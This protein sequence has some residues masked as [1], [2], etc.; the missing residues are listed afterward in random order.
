M[1]KLLCL[2]AVV[3]I[4]ALAGN[5]WTE[6]W[7]V[8]PDGSNA[9][10]GQAWDDAFQTIQ[11]AI[12]SAKNADEIWVAA[13]R[14]L[15]ENTPSPKDYI[16]VQK[17][18]GIYGGF[19]GTEMQRQERD[20]VKN[21]T[22]VDGGNQVLCFYVKADATID[23]FTIT[24]GYDEDTGYAGGIRNDKCSPTI[25]NC[26]FRENNGKYNGGGIYNYQESSPTIYNCVFIGNT[27][28]NFGG[29]IYNYFKSSPRIINCTFH[30]NSAK[31]TGGAIYNYNDSSPTITNC[32]FSENKAKSGGGIYN[33][34]SSPII[35]N[36]VLWGDTAQEG[37]EI[38]G[39]GGSYCD[40]AYS[41]IQGG[42]PGSENIDQHPGFVDPGSGDFHLTAK[43]PCINAGDP[44]AP[45]LPPTD[46]EGDPR[47]DK[48]DM[49]VDE[50]VGKAV[51]GLKAYV[52]YA[53]ERVRL[54]EIGNSEG[55]VGSNK[56]IRI[57]H[58]NSGIVKGNLCSLEGIWVR[59][60]IT[61]D[62]DVL[63]NG[64]IH[65]GH[66]GRHGKLAV[67]GCITEGEAAGLSPIDLP[68][69]GFT[70]GGQD[71]EV[72]RNHSLSLKP[73][74]YGMVQVEKGATLYLSSGDYHMENLTA[75]R[76]A[77]ISV[78]LSK[79][80]IR[81][82]VLESLRIGHHVNIDIASGMTHDVTINVLNDYLIWIG[83]H[84]KLRGTL[85]APNSMVWLRHGSEI[86]GAVYAR[87]IWVGRKV[88]FQPHAD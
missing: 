54:R 33:C 26:T 71:I 36:S 57:V 72:R 79:G 59:G 51:D 10:S 46:C 29:A 66:R 68:E 14:Y 88:R 81:I 18:V 38:S 87:G 62:G 20:W 35:T 75:R 32:T 2:I 56:W 61:I 8:R 28:N 65:M 6:V 3:L 19:N 82:N 60:S 50:F 4:F 77:T 64:Q 40:V 48:P 13:G 15:L 42:Y 27:A 67:T 78:D 11:K 69:I 41:N 21:V 1:R 17:A 52:L 34:Y 85:V 24:N 70:A 7:H 83:S 45:L 47:D 31:E 49:G 23:G 74:S 73:E 76:G 44:D 39:S 25:A 9:N 63:T 30:R 22:R 37:P 80:P 55:N 53:G 5:A 43:S 58:G 84:A 12:D 16:L 86:E